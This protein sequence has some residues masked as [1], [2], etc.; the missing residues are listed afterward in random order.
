[1]DVREALSAVVAVVVLA[2]AVP[3]GSRVV[4]GVPTADGA[5]PRRPAPSAVVLGIL[6]VLVVGVVAAVLRQHPSWLPA[7]CYL[8]VLGVWLAA[9][10]IRVHRLP[11]H[12]VLPSYPVL[13][14]L[15]GFAALVDGDA[16]RLVRAA[17]AG[18]V[19]WGVFLALHRLPGAGLGRGDVKLVGL[20]GAALGWLGWTSALFGL[21]AGIVLGGVTALGLLVAG[22]VGRRDHL[23]YGP[24]LLGGALLAVLTAS[25]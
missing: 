17:V 13:A 8:G 22:R 10:D 23:A 24:F 21:F 25:R 6:T 12:L 18:A 9:I 2:V 3:L 7:Y 11:D 14:V 19:C 20:L 16:G 15:L 1:V 5:P 4:A